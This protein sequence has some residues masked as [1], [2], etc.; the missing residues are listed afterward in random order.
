MLN[1]I[2]LYNYWWIG[3]NYGAMLTAYALQ[4][5]LLFY[6]NSKLVDNQR[7]FNKEINKNYNFYQQFIIF[8]YTLKTWR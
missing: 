5:T 8:I 3:N 1:N 7:I 4:K 6:S 2:L